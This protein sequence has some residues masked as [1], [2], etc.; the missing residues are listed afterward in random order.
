MSIFHF[1]NSCLGKSLNLNISEKARNP[2]FQQILKPTSACISALLK[3][4]VLISL[5]E[6]IDKLIQ[7]ST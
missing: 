6:Y 5:N 3:M 4:S 2:V 7:E 1:H